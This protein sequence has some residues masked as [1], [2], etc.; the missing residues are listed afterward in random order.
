MAGVILILLLVKGKWKGGICRGQF[1]GKMEGGSIHGSPVGWIVLQLTDGRITC[2]EAICMPIEAF[3]QSG[4][5]RPGGESSLQKEGGGG[6]GV[7]RWAGLME[8][9]SWTGITSL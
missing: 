5:L 4:S 6:G 7:G 3:L 1:P 9:S 2:T 8:G